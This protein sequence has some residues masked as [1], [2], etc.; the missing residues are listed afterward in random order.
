M[1]INIIINN[2]KNKNKEL[3]VIDYIKIPFKNNSVNEI[4][5]LIYILNFIFKFRNSFKFNI[6]VNYRLTNNSF[7]I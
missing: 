5:I 3:N 2:I 6:K 7:N 1:E 4:V